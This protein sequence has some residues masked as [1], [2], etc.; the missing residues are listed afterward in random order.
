LPHLKSIDQTKGRNALLNR[1]CVCVCV[2][3]RARARVFGKKLKKE[4]NKSYDEETR[5]ENSPFK[6]FF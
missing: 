1:V 4:K 3:A 6:K 2:C 5:G